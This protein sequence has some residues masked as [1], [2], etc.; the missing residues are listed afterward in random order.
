M[1]S[2]M[3]NKTS[4]THLEYVASGCS[5]LGVFSSMLED[6]EHAANMKRLYS[7]ANRDNDS[8][9]TLFNA[10]TEE[11]LGKWMHSKFSD[12]LHS[13][14]AD[15]GGLQMITLNRTI[16]D[17]FKNDIYHIQGKYSTVAM[18]FDEIPVT[19]SGQIS[20]GS[21][22]QRTF[23]R[24]T[25]KQKAIES[26]LNIKK[27]IQ[28][29]REN[30]YAAKPMLIVQG[31]CID[32]FRDWMNYVSDAVGETLTDVC[33]ISVAGS[34]IGRG[35]LEDIERAACVFLDAPTGLN[36]N[37]IHLLGVG[38]PSRFVPYATLAKQFANKHI[39]YD[40]TTHTKGLYTGQLFMGETL[41]KIFATSIP[42]LEFIA[43]D[44]SKLFGEPYTANDIIAVS[45]GSLGFKE[46]YNIDTPGA[47]NADFII[48]R[49]MLFLYSVIRTQ[50][51]IRAM[52]DRSLAGEDNIS[53]I[54]ASLK[55][56]TCYN[57][58]IHWKATYG[59]YVP[60]SRV[61]SNTVEL[62]TLDDM[63]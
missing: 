56:V 19:T 34:S 5:V 17:Q 33:G 52:F 20:V 51:E 24:T 35:E 37:K 41:C 39:S 3:Q 55:E 53:N 18:S 26:G 60:T 7:F 62:V 13:I 16:T 61:P 4:T 30:S 8:F 15:S 47:R 40:S 29:F 54:Y 57:D 22:K 9:S 32:T 58:F 63:F 6:D 21:M 43:E 12:N 50:Q 38:S 28:V 45:R 31:N 36:T 14:H 46:K 25:F 27:Q 1:T 10:Y 48:K 59:K 44:I 23:D 2:L 11:K 42:K 49:N